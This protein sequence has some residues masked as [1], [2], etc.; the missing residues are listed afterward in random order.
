[1][2]KSHYSAEAHKLVNEIADKLVADHDYGRLRWKSVALVLAEAAL[3]MNGELAD[4]WWGEI[5]PHSA[6][7]PG[8]DL[9]TEIESVFAELAEETKRG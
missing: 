7:G 9:D 4:L 6:D 2:A 3:N 5:A 1:M 8:F